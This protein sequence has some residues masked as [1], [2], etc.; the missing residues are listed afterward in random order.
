MS[1]D[2]SPF[3]CSDCGDEDKRNRNCGNRKGL[4]DS[5]RVVG[6]FTEE[7]KKEIR[8]KKMAKVFNL[9]DLRLYECPL[10]YITEDTR[11]MMSVIYR[12]NDSGHLY[13]AGGWADQ[14][15]WLVEGFT[16]YKIESAR[17]MERRAVHGGK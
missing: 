1:R 13:Y 15:T 3:D 7:I 4:I 12:T 16:I 5:A 14:P 10:S 9:G 6:V 2:G 8:E 11:D 17:D